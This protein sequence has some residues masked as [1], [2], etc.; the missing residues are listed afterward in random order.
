LATA[1]LLG[2][3]ILLLRGARSPTAPPG[4]VGFY[5]LKGVHQAAPG[6]IRNRFWEG[7]LQYF[8]HNYSLTY[9]SEL[10]DSNSSRRRLIVA[11]NLVPDDARSCCAKTVASWS[12]F[13]DH[14]NDKRWYV[15]GVY[16]TFF[17][18]TALASVIEQMESNGNPM[19]DFLMSFGLFQ[20]RD[21]LYPHGGSGWILSHF[22]VRKFWSMRTKFLAG[23]RRLQADDLTMPL[24]MSHFSLD[25]K[26]YHMNRFVADWPKNEYA[27]R[28]PEKYSFSG[29]KFLFEPVMIREAVGIHMHEIPLDKALSKLKKVP[30]NYAM[31]VGDGFTPT[32]C[33]KS[34]EG[35]T[36]QMQ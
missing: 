29:D 16:D 33:R 8:P 21:T 30:Y 7:Q 36:F 2:I 20:W 14:N 18:L 27:P 4:S 6:K 34:D 31:T 19:N 15:R 13:I 9:V 26:R 1:G 11:P 23:C 32:F 10:P 35:G 17:N 12:D 5:V 24:L 28:C 3:W 25:V 22:A